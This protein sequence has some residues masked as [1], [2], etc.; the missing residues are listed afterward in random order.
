M[1]S[2]VPASL[3]IYVFG[4]ICCSLSLEYYC[5][6]NSI[7]QMPGAFASPKHN[8]FNWYY[9]L[10]QWYQHERRHLLRKNMAA[11]VRRKRASV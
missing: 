11:A 1:Y 9:V 7:L 4:I 6:W 3:Y 5:N 10:Y 8:A 2:G